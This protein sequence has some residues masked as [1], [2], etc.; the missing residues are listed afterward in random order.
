M[1]GGEDHMN[2][3]VR[4]WLLGAKLSVLRTIRDEAWEQGNL[5]L[6]RETVTRMQDMIDRDR[7]IYEKEEREDSERED[8]EL[9]EVD[10]ERHASWCIC[11]E[12]AGGE[13][14]ADND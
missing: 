13:L 12:C 3:D 8:S 10:E 11:V 4:E 14:T 7:V 6:W 9:G 5:P 1:G 2:Q